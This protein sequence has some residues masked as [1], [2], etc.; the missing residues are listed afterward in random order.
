MALH[1][2]D[3]TA[4][5]KSST[6]QRRDDGTNRKNPFRIAMTGSDFYWGSNS[7]AA[8]QGRVMLVAWLLTRE[9]VYLEGA[10][11]ACDYLFGRNGNRILLRDGFRLHALRSIRTTG[12]STADGYKP[13]GARFLVGRTERTRPAGDCTEK[14]PARSA[15][16]GST[17]PAPIRQMR[18][19]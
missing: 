6:V 13:S 2:G 15:S 17:L 14:Y 8:N 19:P 1:K 9:A 10:V 5:K 18:S 7:V 16:R 4:M 3:S 12:P 11:H